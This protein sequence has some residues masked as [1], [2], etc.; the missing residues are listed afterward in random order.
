MAATSWTF[1]ENIVWKINSPG[2][3][4]AGR[5]KAVG[6]PAPRPSPVV[7]GERLYLLTDTGVGL[8]TSRPASRLGASSAADTP[9]L[10]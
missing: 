9:H 4:P 8:S 7:V 1:P 3:L 2:P 10:H 5:P 6:V